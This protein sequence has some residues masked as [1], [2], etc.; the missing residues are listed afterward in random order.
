MARLLLFNHCKAEIFEWN[1]LKSREFGAALNGCR[2]RDGCGVNRRVAAEWFVVFQ[3]NGANLDLF[4]EA[5]FTSSGGN[6]ARREVVRII[7]SPS[8]TGK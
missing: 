1:K 5:K 3:E 7:K 4:G 2:R 6:L 8:Q